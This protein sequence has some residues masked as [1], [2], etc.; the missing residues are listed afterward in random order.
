MHGRAWA[1]GSSFLCE[2]DSQVTCEVARTRARADPCVARLEAN[3]CMLVS[4]KNLRVRARARARAYILH[5]H[6]YVRAFLHARSGEIRSCALQLAI[7]S[8]RR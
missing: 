1:R 8:F 6:T 7:A 3:P 4:E 2:S 5:M